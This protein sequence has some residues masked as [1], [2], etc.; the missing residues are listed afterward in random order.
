MKHLRDKIKRNNTWLRIEIDHLGTRHQIHCSI[1][2]CTQHTSKTE[3][4][5]VWNNGLLIYRTPR[6]AHHFL[7][8]MHCVLSDPWYPIKL[9]TLPGY[10]SLLSLYYLCV[11]L[12]LMALVQL[13][14]KEH[15]QRHRFGFLVSRGFSFVSLHFFTALFWS[16]LSI[17]RWTQLPSCSLCIL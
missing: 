4:Q 8:S 6:I 12:I 13:I 17:N 10:C 3:H 11:L 5:Y 9:T 14:V 1:V 15:L 7:H 2:C 16:C